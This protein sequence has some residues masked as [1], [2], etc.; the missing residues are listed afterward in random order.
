MNRAC[1]PACVWVFFYGKCR[2]INTFE[3]AFMFMNIWSISLIEKL[4]GAQKRGFCFR[5]AFLFLFLKFPFGLHYFNRYS[6]SDKCFNEISNVYALTEQWV[7]STEQCRKS[8][9]QPFNYPNILFLFFFRKFLRFPFFLN[10]FSPTSLNL[11]IFRLAFWWMFRIQNRLDLTSIR[12]MYSNL[13]KATKDGIWKVGIWN[14]LMF[15]SLGRKPE[16]YNQSWTTAQSEH[17]YG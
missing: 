8:K 4:K 10:T 14:A 2:A 3:S 6:L 11:L 16:K 13:N 1:E 12:F 15:I 5:F 9:K 17:I 7:V